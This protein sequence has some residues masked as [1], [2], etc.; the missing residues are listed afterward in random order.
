VRDLIEDGLTLGV[1]DR[2]HPEAVAQLPG[3]DAAF[4]AGDYE[5][6]IQSGSLAVRAA[7]LTRLADMP[8]A[9]PQ[10]IAALARLEAE[11][12]LASDERRHLDAIAFLVRPTLDPETRF[13][14]VH[15]LRRE[16]GVRRAWL[17]RRKVRFLPEHPEHILFL[18][19]EPMLSLAPSR[20]EWPRHLGGVRVVIL[21]GA[22]RRLRPRLRRI[23]NS[24]LNISG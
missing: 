5:A 3:P 6:A 15:R 4:I 10:W 2:V 7:A 8:G 16:S 9:D 13:A 22:M 1:L 11:H 18:E 14:I 19:L 24:E 12:A 23:S 21:R 20:Q 17:V